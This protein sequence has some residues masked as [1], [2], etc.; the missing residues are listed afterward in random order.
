MAKDIE[1]GMSADEEEKEYAQV[2][3]ELKEWYD[4][5]VDREK[6]MVRKYAKELIEDGGYEGIP[7]E[8][9]EA[10]LEEVVNHENL[11]TKE[12]AEEFFNA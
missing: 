11:E 8:K 9:I 12:N 2:E 4:A 7:Q 3:P 5:Q 1:G 10:V 6:D